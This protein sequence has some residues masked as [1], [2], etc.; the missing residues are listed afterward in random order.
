MKDYIYGLQG[1]DIWCGECNKCGRFFLLGVK[2]TIKDEDYCS[3]CR[4]KSKK[5]LISINRGSKYFLV[6]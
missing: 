4:K 5:D 6:D 2:E 3:D 1:L